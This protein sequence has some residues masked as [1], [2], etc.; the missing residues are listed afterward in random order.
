MSSHSAPTR[1]LPPKPSLAQLRKQAKE[2]LHSYRAGKHAAVAEVER[3]ERS[4]D[5]ANFALADAQ[6]V[7]ARAYSFSSW[8]ALK[9]HVEGV[10]FQA[11][12]AAV[13]AGDEAAVRRIGKVRP[14]LVDQHDGY[15]GGALHHA[16]L[17]R[18]EEM[19]RL[20]MQLGANA[21]VGIWPHRDATSPYAIAVDREYSEMVAVIE[22]EEEHRRARLSHE[23][24]PEN[25]AFDALRQAIIEGRS[26]DAI[27]LMEADPALIGSCDVYGVTPLHVA[28]WKHDL[29]L[30]SWLLDHRAS[31]GAL[32]ERS[33]PVR[34]PADEYP[35]ESGKT[36]LDFAAFVAG[37]APDR[38]D[39]IFYFMERAHADPALFQETAR[40]LL[41]KGA[42]L[43]PRA[44]VALGNREAVQQM[45]REGRL[46]NE[47]HFVRGGLLS[48]AVRVN[49]PDMVSLLLDLGLDPDESVPTDDGY[50][51]WGMP[52][53]FASMCDRFEIA[54]LLLARGADVNGVVY[55]CGD[56]ICAAQ[57]EH[58][59]GLLRTH[60]ARLTVETVSDPKVAQAILDGIMTA[61][62]LGDPEPI[63][64]KDAPELLF[65]GSDPEFVRICLRHIT[66]QRDDPW[67]HDRLRVATSPE[68]LRLILEHGI[69]PN[70]LDASGCTTLHH[71]ASGSG[72]WKWSENLLMRAKMLLDAGA[73]L[74]IRDSLL[75]STPLGWACRWGQIDLVKM[76]LERGADAFEAD[77]EPWAT[78]LAWATKRGHH[79]IVELLRSRGA[80]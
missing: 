68:A 36:P 75:K 35:V 62:T 12:L 72:C 66:R 21:R 2:L 11:L 43:T 40:L 31:T 51:S 46:H 55:A 77:S 61:Y 10:N 42:E 29:A 69:D 49:R 64:P 1:S 18:N 23:A 14:D 28:A 30:V 59:Q 19:T 25:T 27:A 80:S 39:T 8:A 16:V 6:R 13:E 57:D 58:M 50:R 26:V 45:H 70:V 54:E 56:S 44:A 53:W 9:N 22:R 48:V 52:L 33:V 76:Y 79:E 74:T 15:H 63:K 24:P 60:G 17:R 3:F 38:P 67:W 37:R 47:I 4:P 73:S 7:L 5:P 20:L 71:F 65:G 78:P 32:A 41:Q 34:V